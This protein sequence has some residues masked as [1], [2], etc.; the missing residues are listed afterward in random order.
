MSNKNEIFLGL[1]IL[2]LFSIGL[3]WLRTE[4]VKQTY[5]YVQQEKDYRLLRQ[6]IQAIRMQWLKVTSPRRL[7]SLAK[8]LHL[9]PVPL[10][11][12]LKYEPQGQQFVSAP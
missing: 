7:E 11:R 6:D 2:G 1:F 3:I 12:I 5:L 10:N 9:N 8:T 4:T